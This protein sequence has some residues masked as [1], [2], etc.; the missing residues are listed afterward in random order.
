M[1][2]A[3][4]DLRV[5]ADAYAGGRGLVVVVPVKTIS[6]PRSQS[7]QRKPRILFYHEG[8]GGTRRNWLDHIVCV[9]LVLLRSLGGEISLTKSHPCK[10]EA[11]PLDHEGHGGIRRNW[12]DH[13]E[14]VDLVL[15]RA[16]G[17]ESSLQN[18][19]RA[20]AGQFL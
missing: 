1:A 3:A 2:S 13:I 16:L 11:I 19:I 15:L 8:H 9:D 6:P 20:N 14:R 18:R 7:T 5:G 4:P 17:G 12:L 10:R